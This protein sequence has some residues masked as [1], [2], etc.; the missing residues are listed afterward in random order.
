MN[1]ETKEQ[2][3][4]SYHLEGNNL[5]EFLPRPNLFIN[6]T[7]AIDK[8]KKNE[9]T[10]N[11]FFEILNIQSNDRIPIDNLVRNGE[12]SKKTSTDKP[13]ITS[14]NNISNIRPN[15]ADVDYKVTFQRGHRMFTKGMKIYGP[16]K[17]EE[18]KE[19]I[20][21]NRPPMKRAGTSNLLFRRTS[22]TKKPDVV[23][24]NEEFINTTTANKGLQMN[25]F[26]K[27]QN[28]LVMFCF[29]VNFFS[30]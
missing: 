12:P 6:K 9:T 27:Y 30:N 21:A 5:P 3:L 2:E 4:F 8:I 13:L 29:V 16:P 11:N 17:N 18:K 1:K 19:N 23:N 28:F 26:E 22:K 20:I 7:K 24:Q 14:M 25:L 10:R 15:T